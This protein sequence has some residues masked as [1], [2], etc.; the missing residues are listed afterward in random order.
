MPDPDFAAGEGEFAFIARHLRPLAAGHPGA[1]ELTDDAALVEPTAGMQLVLAKDALVEGVHF[2]AHDAADHIAQKALRVNLSDMAAMGATPR[3]YLLALMRPQRLP[4]EWLGRFSHG[5]GLDQASF[6]ITLLG[7]DTVVTPGPLTLSV[8][9]MGEAPRG[10]VLRRDGA[11]AGDDIYV[12]GT[13][14]SAALGLLVLQGRLS[15]PM[16]ASDFLIRR[17]RLP[18]PRIGLGEALRG[19]AHAAIDISDGLLSDLGHVLEA[20]GRGAEIHTHR[21]P[22]SQAAAPHRGALEAA[23][24]GGDDYELLFSAHPE[25]RPAIQAIGQQ[26]SLSLTVIGQITDGADLEILDAKG[27]P[28][29]IDDAGWRHF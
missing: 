9:M 8:T 19:V 4:P 24:A 17:Y 25:Q 5:L 11:R 29:P 15:P 27:R 7:G 6:G 21:I 20:S 14:G 18:E 3:G 16:S 22:L 2:L 1:L 12:S 10:Q 23:L 26:L 13:L 28:Y